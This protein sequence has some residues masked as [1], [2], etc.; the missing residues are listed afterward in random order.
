MSFSEGHAYLKC[1]DQQ[2][3]TEARNVVCTSE[4][5]C[6]QGCSVRNNVLACPYL[7][8]Q[9]FM[10]GRAFAHSLVASVPVAAVDKYLAKV[11]QLPPALAGCKVGS[12]SCSQRAKL[13]YVKNVPTGCG[14]HVCLPV[15]SGISSMVDRDL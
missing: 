3:V 15:G 9:G 1:A 2:V 5:M 10:S 4:V 7:P 13:R 11:D 6:K 8:P 14:A 12:H